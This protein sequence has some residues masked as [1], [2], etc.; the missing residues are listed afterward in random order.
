MQ[1]E[2]LVALFQG[3]FERCK[4]RKGETA[5]VLSGERSSPAYAQAAL[6]AI[7]NLGA[8][9]FQMHMPAP[10]AQEKPDAKEGTYVGR[11]AVTGQRL[12]GGTPQKGGFG[13]GPPL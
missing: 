3:E 11:T 5:I 1:Q 2:K 8:Q 4:V 12:G 10:P 13:G 7:R 6:L 9:G